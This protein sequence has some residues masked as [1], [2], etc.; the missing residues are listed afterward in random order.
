MACPKAS[1]EIPTKSDVKLTKGELVA[2]VATG[3][4]KIDIN[5]EFYVPIM[6][7][8]PLVKGLYF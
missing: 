4:R 1:K 8:H 6:L 5:N 3:S 2:V 7:C